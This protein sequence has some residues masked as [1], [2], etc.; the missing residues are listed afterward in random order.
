[1]KYETPVVKVEKFEVAH[2]VMLPIYDEFIESE[3]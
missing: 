2:P 1:M 3:L